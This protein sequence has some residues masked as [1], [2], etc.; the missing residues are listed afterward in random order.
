MPD[1][2][3]PLNHPQ[4]QGKALA[5]E[6]QSDAGQLTDFF[7]ELYQDQTGYVYLGL[8]ESSNGT[9]PP[10]FDQAFFEWPGELPG[11][12]SRINSEAPTKEVY[13][14]PALFS[15]RDAH[16]ANVKGSYCVWAEFDGKVP[17]I[18]E[19]EN[20]GI[21][22][23]SIRVRSSNE[24]HEHW[25]WLSEQW[26]SIPEIEHINRRVTYALGAD[27]SGWDANQILRPPGTRNHKR[28]V[29][30]ELL[31][32]SSRRVVFDWT[33]SLTDAPP[34]LDLPIPTSIPAVEDVIAKI[35]IPPRLFMLFKNGRP[36]GHRS[37]ALMALAFEFGKLTPMLDNDEML[38]IM[39]NAD[40]R[41]GKFSGR[42]DQVKRLLDIISKVRI[43]HPF[44]EVTDEE[45][46]EYEEM[47]TEYD[48]LSI[49]AVERQLD[50]VW[51]G[52]LHKRGFMLI[53]GAPG[54]GK[55]QLSMNFAEKAALGQDFLGH[56]IQEPRKIGFLS[57]E[58]GV[59]EV[60]YF[61]GTQSKGYSKEELN[62]LA[63][64][65]KIYPLGEPLYLNDGN[66][67]NRKK[68]EEII[69]DNHLDGLIIDS[70]G[71]ITPEDLSSE[72]V[73]TILDW[74]DRLR[75][76]L[77]C[78]TWIVHHNRKASGD[79]KRPN[80]LSDV[81]GSQYITAR[82]SSVMC[83]WEVNKQL[84]L[85]PLKIRL[86][87]RPDPIGL[88]RDEYLHH[89]VNDNAINIVTVEKGGGSTYSQPKVDPH[90][91]PADQNYTPTSLLDF[92]P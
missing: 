21:P 20:K 18:S 22:N 80:K 74:N 6:L 84:Q 64:N 23:P 42:S 57:L 2:S 55:S 86:S 82:A 25:Y 79:N 75:K 78:F 49:M 7:R 47:F 53:A 68:I 9:S 41:W 67:R 38:S 72:K 71:S 14:A 81:Y 16:K 69:G 24:G 61:V 45:I 76:R 60:Q 63:D 85:I 5:L 28:G 32:T 59:E 51:E 43:K 29:T 35:S 17:E 48:F 90:M 70:L 4:Q 13:F 8:K 36:E 91:L 27:V 11:L 30:V 26:L 54:V 46:Q 31:S 62:L 83:L 10:K 65:F 92:E 88:V 37:E 3:L 39:L 15:E 40:E 87:Q 34:V 77:E 33:E 12:L 73:R 58:M 89:T 19:L 52:F 56:T 44:E 50:W 66:E 1:Q